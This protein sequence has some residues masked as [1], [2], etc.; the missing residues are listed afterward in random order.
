MSRI[1]KQPLTLPKGVDVSIAGAKLTCKGPKGSLDL[2]IHPTVDIKVD[3]GVVTVTRKDDEKIS[4]AMHG[5]T[6]A[7]LAAMVEGVTNGYSKSLE[8]VGVGY[9]AVQKGNK[10][11]LDVGFANTL[12]VEI[13][14]GVTLK[15]TDPTK[16]SVSGIDKQLVHEIAARIRATRK[17]EPYKGKGVRYA[18]ETI[19]RKAGK[20]AAGAKK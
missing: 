3:A 8:I 20:S 2:A 5:T 11:A 1:G 19:R 12:E 13:P 18:G 4:R 7:H 16:L 17:P 9:R 6:R 14:A 15:I 10:V